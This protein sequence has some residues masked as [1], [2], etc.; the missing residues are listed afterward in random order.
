M[1]I[2]KANKFVA[3]LILVTTLP[4]SLTVHGQEAL[5]GGSVTGNFQIDGQYYNEDKA[6]G[7]TADTMAGKRYGVNGF[8]NL[9]Y[10]NG[11]FTAG[12]RFETYLPP[13]TGYSPQLEGSNIAH[14]FAD[15]KTDLLQITVGNFYEQFGSGLILRTYEEW[16][17]GYDNSLKGL[18]VK[19]N[20]FKGVALKGLVGYQRNY[21]IAYEEGNRGIV[22]GADAEFYLNDIFQMLAESK[23]KVFLGG[24]FVSKYEKMTSKRL[25]R[26]DSVY[27]YKL[28]YNVAAFSG[29]MNLI[30][31]GWN[32]MSEYAYKMNNPSAAN[33]FIYKE[34]QALYSTLSWS[35]KGVG[36]MLGAKRIDNM[37]F[38]SK[39]TETEAILDI[40]FLPPLTK[41]HQYSFATMYPFSSQPNGEMAYQ[42]QLDFK[43]PKGIIGGKYGTQVSVSYSRVNNIKKEAVA[44]GIPIDSTGTAG[45]KS[46]FLSFGD[47]LF[48]SDLSLFIGR[49]IDK[50]LKANIGFVHQE[51]NKNVLEGHKNE[52]PNIIADILIADVTVKINNI[53]AFR[54]E[55]QWLFTKQ[56]KGNWVGGTI[57]YTIAPNWFMAVADEYNYGNDD[58]DLK[59]HYYSVSAGYTEGTTRIAVN[60]GRQREGL[61]CVGG[62]C[63]FVPAA[64]GITLTLTSSF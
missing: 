41:Q 46:P 55:N 54:F 58:P 8:G 7:I 33:N 16:S 37:S 42:A 18:R 23:T 64:N 29:R 57:E 20:P 5:K 62:V 12:L 51:Y 17:L 30:R 45:Y 38:K 4:C 1:K 34:G 25:V 31:G 19:F 63:R 39:M 14:W 61:L 44:E 47:E 48:Y 2:M 9:L 3:F 53:H 43:I 52:Y 40:N 11:N 56:D 10:T 15:Y 26:G 6:L 27:E 22:R 50:S 36:V 59:L 32:F 28:P 24:S 21:W 60:Y 13:M 49:K 35:T